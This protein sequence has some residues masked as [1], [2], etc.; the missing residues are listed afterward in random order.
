MLSRGSHTLP[1][2][3]HFFN[4]MVFFLCVVMLVSPLLVSSSFSFPWRALAWLTSWIAHPATPSNEVPV[5][6]LAAAQDATR[7]H[8]THEDIT[9][10]TPPIRN[11]FEYLRSSLPKP[12]GQWS[13]TALC[14]Q[15]SYCWT[16]W[17][18][19]LCH[20][21]LGRPILLLSVPKLLIVPTIG[22]GHSHTAFSPYLLHLAL[23][24]SPHKHE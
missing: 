21:V 15:R 4:S 1:Q 3:L 11:A 13:S 19:G 16:W 24:L 6:P 5:R 23:T 17:W 9:P 12:S 7:P 8:V 10:H 18:R 22:W 2:H 20:S 14:Y